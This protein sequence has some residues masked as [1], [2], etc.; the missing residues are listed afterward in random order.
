M[1]INKEELPVA[2]EAPGII[3]R[4]QA[5]WGGMTVAYNQFP[6]GA[7]FTPFFEGLENDRCHCPHWGYIF[8]GSVK[9]IYNDGTEEINK[10]GDLFYW[11]AGHTIIMLEDTKLM[12]FSPDKE[13]GEVM[14]VVGKN[15]EKLGG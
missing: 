10:A 7:D 15:M 8:E 9:I 2:M 13:L 5:N 12:D 6:G 11:P 4:N 14:A 3:A 1:K